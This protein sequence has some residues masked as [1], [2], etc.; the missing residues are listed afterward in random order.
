MNKE[1]TDKQKEICKKKGNFVVRACP[2]SGKTFTVAAKMAELLKNWQYS[3]QGVAVISFTNVAWQEIQKELK[4]SFSIN[5]PIKH[6]HFLGTIDSFVNNFI[7]FPY[8]HLI[9]NCKDKAT[10]VGEPAYPWKKRKNG[11]YNQFFDKVSCDING[12]FVT[13]SKV[14]AL[15]NPKHYNH[16]KDMK[17]TFWKKGYVNQSDINYFSMKLIEKYPIIA[18]IISRRFYYILIDEAQDTSAIQMKIIDFLIE[19]G[20]KNLVLVGDPDQAIFEWNNAKPELFNKKM[21][22]LKYL[23]MNENFRSSQK[24]CKFTY[25]LSTLPIVAQSK[26]KFSNY[27]YEPEIWGYNTENPNFD[28]L[29]S[30]FLEL[31][32]SEHIDLNHENVAILCRSKTL[33]REISLSKNKNSLKKINN[34]NPWNQENYAKELFYSKYLYDNLEFQKSFK[35]L[36]KTY[37]SILKGHTIYSN[38]KL[39]KLIQKRGYFDFRKEIFNLIKLMPKTNITLGKWKKEFKNELKNSKFT[40]KL[41]KE[42]KI[43]DKALKLHFNDV[44]GVDDDVVDEK[45][46]LSTIHKVKGE[47]FEAILLILKQKTRG[48]YYKTL[49]KNNKKTSD[50][51]ELRNVYVGIT[52][53]RRILVLA[54]PTEDEE[55]WN[56]YFSE[57]RVQTTLSDF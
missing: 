4:N 14:L 51:E 13:N 47:T 49:L 50:E 52:R 34:I 2:G 39:Y 31:C 28:K 30:R 27:Q 45:Y 5:I 29:I 54:V 25:H 16:I 11:Y 6:P 20:L 48:P 3:H 33:I 37:M 57:K 7:F 53:P 42:L 18:K 55:V 22:E 32:K 15:N 56:D 23:T 24:L 41:I 40:S 10:L 38:Q 9:L 12:N 19:N 44:F 36:G 17:E 43:N 8:A 35:L 1:L 46:L 26:N 21:C